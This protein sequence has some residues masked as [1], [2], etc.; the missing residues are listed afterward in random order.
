MSN[1]KRVLKKIQENKQRR[2][3][4]KYNS[5]PFAFS[6][7]NRISPGIIR[8]MQYN[9]SASSGIGK[10][11]LAKYLFVQSP[12][13]WLK[14]NPQADIKLKLFYFAH[15][16]SIDEFISTMISSQLKVKY[17]KNISMMDLASYGDSQLDDETLEQIKTLESYFADFESH[18]QI[19]DTLSNIDQMYLH[20]KEWLLN[21][22]KLYYKDLKTGK[23]STEKQENYVPS[24]YTPDDPEMYVGV[25]VDHVS[26]STSNEGLH[27]TMSKWSDV[28]TKLL[29]KLYNCF[30]LDI[31]QQSAAQEEIQYT[32]RGETVEEKMVP[33]LS[34]LGDNKKVGRNYKMS[35]GLFA[36]DR[37]HIESYG[38]DETGTK[39]RVAGLNDHIR[40]V[41][42]MKNRF[43]ISNKQFALYF[44]GQ[45]NE[46]IELPKPSELTDSD[47]VAIRNG[48]YN[49]V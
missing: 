7:L 13:L 45:T 19:V 14:Q 17:G 24:H 44:N 29:T 49:K 10:T 15:E 38:S 5:I 37:Y 20:V 35:L 33:T 16:E 31:Q 30:T 8:G 2:E 41:T 3:E 25:I 6:K 43:G 4:G 27:Q 32:T 21:H 23:I 1:F 46:F 18:I 9:I 12:Y 28:Y 22:G 39:Y 34:G 48:T 11:Q 36:P 42:V 26:L 47:Y 40:F